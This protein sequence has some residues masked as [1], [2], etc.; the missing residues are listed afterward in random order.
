[1]TKSA[2]ALV[3]LGTN[4]PFEGRGGV[5]LLRA[6]LDALEARG[7]PVLAVS[8]AWR[9]PAWPPSDQPDF[10]NAVASLDAGAQDPPS[11]Y[12]GLQSVEVQFGRE[13]RDLWAARTLDL[14]LI[15]LDGFRGECYGIQIPHPRAHTRAFVLAPLA[16]IEPGWRPELRDPTALEL[17]A[18]LPDAQT[19]RRI[20]PLRENMPP[21]AAGEIA[22]RPAKD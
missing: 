7:L 8:S 14:D 18:A 22:L 16:E 1:M 19:V 5:E 17:L 6:A 4:L 3:A 9:S 2:R 11:L 10:V 15:D 12:Q 13:R 21:E 20:G